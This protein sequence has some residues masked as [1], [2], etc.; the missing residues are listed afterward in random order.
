MDACKNRTRDK[1]TCALTK[2]TV[3]IKVLENG[4]PLK[5][6]VDKFFFLIFVFLVLCVNLINHLLQ[7]FTKS[8]V[9]KYVYIMELL[10]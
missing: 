4:L 10:K 5:Q 9:E 1:V 7:N 8:F 6:N 2:I 3:Y